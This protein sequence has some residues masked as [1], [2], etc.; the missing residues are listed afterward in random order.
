MIIIYIGY[1]MNL[2]SL[3]LEMFDLLLEIKMG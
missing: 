3:I 2:L 1:G